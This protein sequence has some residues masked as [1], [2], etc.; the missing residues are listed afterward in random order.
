MR[1]LVPADLAARAAPLIGAPFV[2]HGDAPTGWDCRGL[3]RWCL[4]EFCGVAVPDYR[5]LYTAAL[6]EPRALRERARLIATGLS[7]WRQVEAQAGTVAW[8][9]WLGSA[10]HVGFLLS[11]SRVLHA[12]R[13]GGTAILDLDRPESGYR[14]LGSYVP[15]FVTDIVHER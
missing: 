11:P 9:Q 7:A 14:L 4:R 10:G 1:M 12:D 3:S 13:R 5:D 8:L 2:P 6:L 15:S